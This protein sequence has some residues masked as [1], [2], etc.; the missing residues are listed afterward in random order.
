MANV[1]FQLPESYNFCKPDKWPCWQKH[2]E[3]FC[4]ASGLV[5]EGEE[6]QV[7]TQLYYLGNDAEDVLHFTNVSEEDGKKYD[8][9]LEKF[10]QFFQVQKNIIIE[11][12]RFNFRK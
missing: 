3:Q 11:R 6:R 5:T 9:M 10:D 1:H 8:K 7:N 12:A 2:F 4:I